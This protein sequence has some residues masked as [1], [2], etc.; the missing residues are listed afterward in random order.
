MLVTGKEKYSKKKLNN[1]PIQHKQRRTSDFKSNYQKPTRKT[2]F[3]GDSPPRKLQANFKLN[4][5]Q[6][7]LIGTTRMLFLFSQYGVFCSA[8]VKPT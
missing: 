3:L 8:M 6:K 5:R 4:T 1:Y 2:V 7:L